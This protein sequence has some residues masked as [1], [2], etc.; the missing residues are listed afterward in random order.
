LF[1]VIAVSLMYTGYSQELPRHVFS[2]GGNNYATGAVQLSWTIGQAEPLA[3]TQQPIVILS[4]GFQQFDDMLVSVREISE[5]HEI[6]LYPNPCKDFAKLQMKFEQ[7]TVICYTLYDFS[8]RALLSQKLS[9]QDS[10]METISFDGLSPG[11]YNLMLT[12]ESGE[13]RETKSF[14]LIRN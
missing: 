2:S 12:I 14:K 8:G 1:M 10:Y 13:N 11:I 9:G 4:S 6:L 7:S 5:D 3:T